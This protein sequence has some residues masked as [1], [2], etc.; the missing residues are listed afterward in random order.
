MV[1]AAKL[2]IN[3]YEEVEHDA[4]VTMQAFLVVLIVAVATGI[5]AAIDSVIVV[6]A[7]P[8]S[9]LWGLLYGLG[10]AIFGWLMWSL[11]AYWLGTTLFRGPE[12][13]ATYGQLL[14]TLGF[15]N[16]P[17]LL[18]IFVFVPFIGG[19]IA[20]AGSIW[21]LVAGVIAVRQALDFS[22]WR[23]IGTCIVGWIL[24][25]IL[26]FVIALFIPGLGDIF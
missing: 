13:E 24:Y 9:F 21:V 20:L 2:D 23:A 11:F 6:D 16:T 22:T 5:G 3:L 7:E 18:R 17:G 19:L 8:I 14:R 1:R 25:M 10:A 26:V 4:S 12:T 15:A